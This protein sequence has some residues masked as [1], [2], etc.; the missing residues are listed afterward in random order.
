V[1]IPSDAVEPAPGDAAA[2]LTLGQ[3]K[4][5]IDDGELVSSEARS[6]VSLLLRYL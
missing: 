5:L 2:W 3:L 6:A 1:V 4:S